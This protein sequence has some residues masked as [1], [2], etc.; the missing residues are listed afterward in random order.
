[1]NIQLA[2][3]DIDDEEIKLVAE[4]LKSGWLAHGPKNKEFEEIFAQYIGTKYAVSLNSCT[5]ALHLAIQA[6]GIKGEVIIPSFT[7][8][9]SA[10]AVVTAGAK[11]VFVDIDYDTCNINTEKIKRLI[12]GK[13]EAI[14]PVHFA[15]QSCKMDEITEIANKHDIKIIEDSAETLGGTFK[16]K[17]TGSFGTGCFSFYP[18]KN[19]T[20][21]EGGM[22]TTNDGKLAE[23]I[24]SL[25][26]HG[27][28]TTAFERLR[29]NEPWLRA[30]EYAGYNY[31][32]CD[33]LAAIGLV[34]MKKLEKMNSLRREHANYLDKNLSTI[35]KIDLPVESK[36]CKHVYQ[37]YTIKLKE[38]CDRTKFISELRKKGIGASVHF[39]PP[40]HK[41]PFYKNLAHEDLT[42]TEE[43]SRSIVTLPIYPKLTKAELDYMVDT[44]SKTIKIC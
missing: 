44:I 24:R 34:Q 1:M 20:T 23:R 33:I 5:S 13:T 28:T 2:V 29:E 25:R 11:P 16:D 35:E 8:V 26:A 14:M 32:L 31:R 12:T 21:G 38:G 6:Q 19:I 10:N 37:M 42:I 27:I 36:N 3:P 15:G 41:Q 4:V 30:A 39:D 18:T 7:F 40:V 9:A 17:K 22:V 43:V